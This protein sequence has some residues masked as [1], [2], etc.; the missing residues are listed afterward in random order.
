M[1]WI[2]RTWVLLWYYVL[3]L[4]LHSYRLARLWQARELATEQ[5]RQGVAGDLAQLTAIISQLQRAEQ[6]VADAELDLLVS[7]QVV[8]QALLETMAAMGG[9]FDQICPEWPAASQPGE[10]ATRAA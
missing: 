7:Q 6:M 9:R 3:L 5:V 1:S 8:Q 10:Q 2:T 4:P